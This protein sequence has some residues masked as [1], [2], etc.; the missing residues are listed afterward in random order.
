MIHDPTAF[1]KQKSSH[2]GR[3]RKMAVATITFPEALTRKLKALENGL[4]KPIKEAL[5]A[6]GKIALDEERKQLR[7]AIGNTKYKSRS[8]GALYHALGL[9]RPDNLGGEW[10]IKIGFSEPRKN[11][12]SQGK[13][14]KTK[15][16]G[17]SY[18][19]NAMIA[20][21]L[22][23]GKSGQTAQPFNARTKRA[24]KRSVEAAMREIL[25]KAI[26]GL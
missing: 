10:N 1:V 3:D 19:S 16:G 21:V 20:N 7:K 5:I 26:D 6:G 15:G 25:V 14:R 18:V 23:Y 17:Y 12:K 4:E 11:R 13:K 9:S 8:M 22:E 2:A 24:A